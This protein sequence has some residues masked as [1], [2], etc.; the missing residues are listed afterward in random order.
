MPDVQVVYVGPFAEVRFFTGEIER[1]AVRGIPVAVPDGLAGRPP[2]GDDPGAG[3]L[4]Q[5]DNW[6]PAAT[7]TPPPAPAPDPTPAPEA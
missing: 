3:L 1:S 5:P 4:A 2:S 6:Q 7:A